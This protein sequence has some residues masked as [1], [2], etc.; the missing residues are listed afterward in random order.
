MTGWPRHGVAWRRFTRASCLTAYGASYLAL[1]IR[2]G[3]ALASLDRRLNEAAAAEGVL[4][5]TRSVPLHQAQSA[6]LTG[7]LCH[8]TVQPALLAEEI[9]EPSR[10]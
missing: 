4:P 10:D 1:A 2:E 8:E 6:M 9:V 5:F 3:C 7:G